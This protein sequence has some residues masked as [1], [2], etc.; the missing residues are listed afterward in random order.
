MPDSILS[1]S[2]IVIQPII[3]LYHNGNHMQK[4]SAHILGSAELN[5][6]HLH[7]NF[8]FLMFFEIKVVHTDISGKQD[9]SSI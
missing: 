9:R 1:I 8:E 4:Y 3:T 7:S 5:E 6:N 2:D